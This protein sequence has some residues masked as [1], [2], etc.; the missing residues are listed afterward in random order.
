M[1]SR[2]RPAD[3]TRSAEGAGGDGQEKVTGEAFA[4][5]TVVFCMGNRLWHV[6]LEG[7][8]EKLGM[9]RVVWVMLLCAYMLASFGKS[10]WL[11]G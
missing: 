10:C 1:A 4:S 5:H 11:T 9:V 2:S 3:G 6:G 7:I 8:V